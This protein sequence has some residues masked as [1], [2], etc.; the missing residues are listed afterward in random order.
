MEARMCFEFQHG[1]VDKFTNISQPM[2]KLK[3]HFGF[4]DLFL[5][6]TTQIYV[7]FLLE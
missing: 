2:L 4:H 3:A 6:Y 7:P 5:K 1:L